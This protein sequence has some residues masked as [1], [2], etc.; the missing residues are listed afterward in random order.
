M[1]RKIVS[2]RPIF[3]LLR[4]VPHYRISVLEG[5]IN[6]NKNVVVYYGEKAR[7][8]LIDNG[9]IPINEHFKKIKNYY[10]Y[11]SNIFISGIYRYLFRRRPSVIVTVFNLGNLNLYFLFLLRYLFKFKIILWSFGYA[12]SKGFSPKR[13]LSDKIRLYLY[14]K[15]DAVIFYWQKGKEVV[16]KYSERTEHYFVAPNTIDTNKLIEI[17]SNIEKMTDKELRMEL[18]INESVHFVYVGRL[19]KDKQVDFLI[20]AFHVFN[21]MNHDS[22]LTIIGKGPEYENLQ[23]LVKKLNVHNVYFVGEILDPIN[24]GKWIFIS[25]A[26]LMPGRLGNAVVHSFCYGTPV[27][28]QKKDSFYHGEGIGYLKDGI[29]GFLV[30]DGDVNAYAEHLDII[31]KNKQLKNEM[32]L[33]CFKTVDLEC[34]ID[35]MVDGI[36]QALIYTLNK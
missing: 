36:E 27:I 2:V 5:I 21:N 14:Q 33:N 1:L 8:G 32:K 25:E 3:F 30:K 19:I 12:P 11:K 13:K 17:R 22:R 20:R 23:T 4:I 29:N 16:S 24:V 34:S 18:N 15:S 35:K 28:S 31:S 10:I 26:F 9:D 7:N 6:R